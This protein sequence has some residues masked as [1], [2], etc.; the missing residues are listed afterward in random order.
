MISHHAALK[1]IAFGYLH[2]L[3]T[4]KKGTHIGKISH[5]LL[6]SLPAFKHKL[7]SRK[8]FHVDESPTPTLNI[9]LVCC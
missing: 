5:I 3:S 1:N 9:Q 4:K 8:Y 7:R 2:I 6:S